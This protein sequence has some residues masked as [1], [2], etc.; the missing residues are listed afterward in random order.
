M[1]TEIPRIVREELWRSIAW[2]GLALVGWPILVDG[3]A[4]LEQNLFTVFGL[5]VVTWGVLT[6]GM[7]GIRTVSGAELQYPLSS[8]G[9]LLWGAILGVLTAVYLIAVEGYSPLLVVTGEVAVAAATVAWCWYAGV[10]DSST[11]LAG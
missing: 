6:V 10:F 9:V 2:F 8:S 7:I 11:E 3:L 4:W 1:S 5:P